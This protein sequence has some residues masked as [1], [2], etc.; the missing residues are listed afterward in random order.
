MGLPGLIILV[1]FI[2]YILYNY[3][4]NI[5]RKAETMY[6]FDWDENKKRDQSQE[7]WDRL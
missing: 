5:E 2:A 4:V 6:L 1:A 3:V 7:A